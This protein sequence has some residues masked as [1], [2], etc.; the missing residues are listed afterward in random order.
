MAV[1]QTETLLPS[2]AQQQNLME[3]LWGDETTTAI[4]PF[5]SDA[6]GQHS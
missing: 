5:A 6:V 2:V 3:Y 1:Y 4:S